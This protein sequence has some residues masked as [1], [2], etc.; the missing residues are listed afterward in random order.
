VEGKRLGLAGGR[1]ER[2]EEEK[3]KKRK[4]KFIATIFRF[5]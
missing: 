4:R 1:R 3:E 2:K 5:S